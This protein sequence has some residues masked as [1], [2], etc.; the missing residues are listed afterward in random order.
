MSF[1]V[2]FHSESLEVGLSLVDF[3]GMLVLF[4]DTELVDII[5]FV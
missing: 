2:N 1:D 3:V 5:D 4:G